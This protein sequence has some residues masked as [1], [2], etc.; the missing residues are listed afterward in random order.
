M[1]LLRVIAAADARPARGRVVDAS[2]RSAVE[3]IVEDVRR[4]G[5]SAVV[6]HAERFGDVARGAALV[7][8]PE[9]L[10]RVL[11]QLP[12]EQRKA[13]EAARERISAFAIAQRT[14]L[15]DLE[16]TIPGGVMGHTFAP[17]ERAG[18]Y[19]PGGRY[20][21]PSSVLMTACTARAA[22]VREVWVA[23]PRP[24][25]VTLAAAALAGV[26]GFLAIGGAQAIGALAYGAGEVP[27][28]DAV[29]GPGSRWVTAAKQLVSGL[30]AI[31]MLAGPSELMILADD[32]ADARVV[33]ADILA[34]AEHD[35]DAVPMLVTTDASLPARVEVELVRQLTS[36]STA[37]TA[38]QALSNGFTAIA[39]DLED[40]IE[41]ADRWAPEHVEIQMKDAATLARRLSHYGALFIGARAAEVL[42]DYGLGPNHTLPTGGTSRS[43]G[44]LSVVNFLRCRTYI[45]MDSE[46]SEQ[47]RDELHLLYAQT[48]AIA[49]ME[50]LEAHA[51]AA[52][53]RR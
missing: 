25:G 1:A 15:R 33:A 11:H 43:Y 27:A 46:L 36:L 5:W 10:L 18:C 50:G 35:I 17:V 28:C 47:A 2:T 31:D 23:S 6:E 49:R 38:I 48:A 32:T 4:R 16:V 34:Q 22:G 40:A 39:N 44:G 7:F 20:P 51:L 45:R 42:G 26:D 30:V 53:A 52:E 13:L 21:L 19:A 9:E 24:A 12:T 37:S 41:C 29:V 8:G 14:C 3:A